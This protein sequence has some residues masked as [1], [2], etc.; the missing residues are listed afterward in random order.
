MSK[1]TYKKDNIIN[2]VIQ[3]QNNNVKAL[4]E[5]IR[6]IQKQIYA[7]FSHLTEKKGDIADLTQEVLLKMAK[8]LHQLKEPKNFKAW[9]NQIITNIYYD[10]A[11]KNPD[12]FIELDEEKLNE[13]KDKLGCEPGEKCLFSELERLVKTALLTLPKDLRI[14]I[15]LREYEGLSYDDIAK[16]T[17]TAIGTVKSRISRARAKLQRELKEFI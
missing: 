15:V 17:N 3:A 12:K 14:T 5:L 1:S 10:Y 9:L 11:K 4:E 7:I 13:I 8:S 2:L 16:I 6:R